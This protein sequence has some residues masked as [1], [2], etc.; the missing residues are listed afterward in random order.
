MSGPLRIR[1]PE[2]NWFKF[3]PWVP[4]CNQIGE[5]YRDDQLL[6]KNSDQGMKA[7]QGQVLDERSVLHDSIGA[8]ERVRPA[9]PAGRKPAMSEEAGHRSGLR[10]RNGPSLKRQQNHSKTSRI[11]YL[12][13]YRFHPVPQSPFPTP[14]SSRPTEPPATHTSIQKLPPP[15]L[16]GSGSCLLVTY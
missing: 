8:E 13:L 10:V 5:S 14:L 2:S 12:S 15:D 7:V 9:A 11:Q 16:S 4:L 1:I 3:S 6:M